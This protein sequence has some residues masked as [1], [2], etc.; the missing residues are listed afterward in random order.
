MDGKQLIAWGMKPGKHFSAAL[1]AANRAQ[2]E[3]RDPRAAAF[4]FM[5]PPQIPLREAHEV[6]HGEFI[7]ADDEV[8]RA[9]LEAVRRTVAELSRT[10][11]I[12]A[13]SVMPDACPT[14]QVGIIPVGGVAAS[15]AIHPGMHSADI[16]CSV[17]ISVVGDADPAG[18]LD[19]AQQVTHFG[20]GGRP[21]GA[22]IRPPAD[23]LSA[24]EGNP[25]LSGLESAAIEHFATQG[26]GNHFLF[27]GRLRSSGEVALVT[28]HGSRKP[29]AMLYKRGMASADKLRRERSPDTLKGNAW[30]EPESGE[31]EAY[32][33]ALQVIREWTKANHFAIHEMV[34]GGREPVDRY[35]NEHNFVFRRGDTFLHGKGATPAWADYAQD[36]SGKVLIP[37]SMGAPILIAEGLDQPDAL[38]F[39]PHGAG[40]NVSRSAHLRATGGAHDDLSGLDIRWF[41][42]VPDPSEMP[43]AYKRPDA[44]EAQ[45]EA[46]GL[47]RI[48]DHVDPY[49]SIMAGDWQVNAP[50]RQKRKQAQAPS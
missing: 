3:G 49:G 5:P 41:S 34:L 20:G 12:T 39:C 18:V 31:G 8:E 25:F 22:Q 17:A 1:R 6:P 32:W 14:G 36:A 4:A 13:T 40:R 38:G 45:I 37:L 48:V 24:F 33:A 21:R 15:K 46:F 30:I 42:G 16:C 29:G 28:H 43:S 26:D 27:V 11:M 35:W 50:W 9:N 7:D 23:V 10:P 19:R 47:A 2:A 44:I